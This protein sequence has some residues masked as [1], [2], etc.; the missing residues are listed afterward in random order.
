MPTERHWLCRL[1]IHHYEMIGITLMAAPV[2]ACVRRNCDRAKKYE[3]YG[4][5]TTFTLPP[6]RVRRKDE[7][8]AD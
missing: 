2:V 5:T 1:G 4:E 6:E 7:L 3:F 8:Y